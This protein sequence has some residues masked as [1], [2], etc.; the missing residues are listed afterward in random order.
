MI[1]ET[2]LTV[3]LSILWNFVLLWITLCMQLTKKLTADL[4]L[5]GTCFESKS[6]DRDSTE[7]FLNFPRLFQEN[8]CYV[9]W[10][11]LRA[12]HFKPF[13]LQHIQ[14]SEGLNNFCKRVLFNDRLVNTIRCLVGDQ[15]IAFALQTTQNVAKEPISF[16]PA[17]PVGGRR[18]SNGLY[19]ANF[20][21]YSTDTFLQQF[22]SN[23][24]II[25]NPQ[26][27]YSHIR[28]QAIAMSFLFLVTTH[29]MFIMLPIALQ[30]SISNL[31]G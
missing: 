23:T 18:R 12:I 24:E 4:H 25:W 13:S 7:K 28:L 22:A 10:N 30:W 8:S 1:W 26:F 14:F 17:T 6:R 11:D 29:R 5:G 20:H 31:C 2:S 16:E 19:T 21:F 3:W 9:P 27:I 15:S